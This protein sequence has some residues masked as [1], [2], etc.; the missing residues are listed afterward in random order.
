MEVT[1][2]YRTALTW[3]V[4]PGAGPGRRAA[5]RS[6][7]RRYRREMPHAGP[8]GATGPP[9]PVRLVAIDVD[10]TLLTSDHRVTAATVAAVG[11]ARARGVQIVPATSRPPSAVWPILERLALLDPAV[12]IAL[13]GAITGTFTSE[14]RLRVIDRQPM[15]LG[16]ARAAASV[17]AGAGLA[18]N[19]YSGEHWLVSGVDDRVRRESRIVECEP[20]VADLA[21]QTTGP[22]KL[23]AMAHRPEPGL[24][25]SLTADLPAGLVAQASGPTY[26]DITRADVDKASALRSLCERLGIPPAAVVVMGDGMND[27]GMFAFAGFAV[28]PANARPEVL[29][30]ADLVTSSND[31]DGVAR[32]LELLIPGR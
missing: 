11:M 7:G 9:V 1:I 32:A 24:L 21:A 23:L 29:A 19:W 31:E 26:L 22:D 13:Q 8:S 14:G 15:D 4:P 5:P 30:V 25:A 10:G 17:A 3:R 18:V 27:L 2:R 16:A 6:R 28:A 20:T 12:F